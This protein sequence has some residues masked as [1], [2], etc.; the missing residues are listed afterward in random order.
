MKI[1]KDFKIA[2]EKMQD[3]LKNESEIAKQND[4]VFGDKSD[5]E[6]R[7][8]ALEVSLCFGCSI[9]TSIFTHFYKV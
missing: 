5:I 3:A 4:N 1:H 6:K 2:C 9:K 7:I 8:K